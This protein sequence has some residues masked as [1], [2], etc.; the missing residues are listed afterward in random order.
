MTWTRQERAS[1]LMS[2]RSARAHAVALV[3]VLLLPFSHAGSRSSPDISDPA[4][5]VQVTPVLVNVAAPEID[6]LGAWA[7]ASASEVRFGWQLRDLSHEVAPGE[8]LDF[9][10]TFESAE[11]EFAA[12]TATRAYG[13]WFFSFAGYRHDGSVVD[14]YG[15]GTVDTA[16]STIEASFPREVV[17]ADMV[18]LTASSI[19]AVRAGER[20]EAGGPAWFRD[21]APDEGD[22]PT[23]QVG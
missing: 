15:V 11:Y 5:D 18:D 1:A 10:L 9:S 13:V 7:S 12:A 21:W 17:N 14:R 23:V 8:A 3:L 4:G 22:G 19:L 20:H 6:I 16:T 2:P